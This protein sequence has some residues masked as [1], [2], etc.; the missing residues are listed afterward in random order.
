[1]ISHIHVARRR[2]LTTRQAALI[3]AVHESTVRRWVDSGILGSYRIGPRAEL[4]FLESE[5]NALVA[6]LHRDEGEETGVL[7]PGSAES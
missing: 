4:R 1:M 5:V 6:K 3:L 7:Q 2:C